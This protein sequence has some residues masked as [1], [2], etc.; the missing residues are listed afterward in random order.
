MKKLLTLATALVASTMLTATAFAADTIKVGVQAP[1]TGEYANEGQA[2][3]Q[4]TRLIV[5]QYNAKGGLLGKKLEVVT[6]DDEGQAVKAAICAKELVNKGVIMVIGSYTSSAAEAA[7]KTY[8]NAGVLQTTDGTSDT[9]IKDGYWTFFRNTN[10]NSAEAVFV[11][12]YMIKVKKYKRIA[13]VADYSSY[14]QDLA[15]AAVAAIKKAGGNL[16]AEEKIKAGSQNFTPILTS[17]KAKNPDVIFFTGYYSDGGLFRSQMAQLGIKADFIG[18]DAN[19]NVDFGKLAG[20]AALGSYIVNVPAPEL[21][22]YDTAKKFL[23]DYQAKY[24]MNV[25][26][27]YT[28]TNADGLLA[29]LSAIEKTKSTDTKKMSEYLHSFSGMPGMTGTLKWDKNG[30]RVGAAFMVYRIKAD[31]KYEV[32]FPTK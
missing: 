22:P 25:P 30:E 13:L 9:L 14:S 1:I 12:D 10:P 24:K 32:A 16:V 3:D 20:K 18:G 28:L 5:D 8:L 15:K 26:S 29:F 6:C 4:A 11:A 17:I 31:G 19:D 2:I 27:I 7:Q 21:L 23:K